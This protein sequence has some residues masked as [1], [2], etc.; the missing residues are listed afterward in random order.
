MRLSSMGVILMSVS[1]LF[2]LM[3]IRSLP[4]RGL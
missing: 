2:T 4:E 1:A 3:S